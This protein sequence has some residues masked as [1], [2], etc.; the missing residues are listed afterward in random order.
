MYNTYNSYLI[1]TVQSSTTSP[2]GNILMT[3]LKLNYKRTLFVGFAFFLILTF[4]QTYDSIIP[5][6]LTDKFGLSQLWSGVIMAA[7]N[8]MAVVLLPL[9]GAIS[10]RHQSRL[11]RRTPFILVGTLAAA[12]ALVG[13]SF[14]DNMQL[15]AIDDISA[16]VQDADG[17]YAEERQDAIIKLYDSDVVIKDGKT[18]ADL[19]GTEADFILALETDED[20]AEHLTLA[21]QAYAWKR[22]CEDPV[23]LIIFIV[24]LLVVLL[25]MAIFRSPAV[26]LMPDITPK[27]LRSKANAII[28]LMGTAGGILVLVLGIVFGTGKT[29]NILMSYTTFFAVVACVML[30]ALAI[31]MITVRE[32]KWAEENDEINRILDGESNEEKETEEKH[33]LGLSKGEKRSLLFILASVVL[34]YIG[35]NAVTSKYS[36]YA[37]DVLGLDF[38]LTLIV[39]QAAAIV[40]YIPVGIISQKVGRR[41]TILAGVAMLFTAFFAASFMRAGSSAIV[42]NILFALAGIGWATINVNSYPM[43]VEMA[44]SDNVGKYTG[45]YYTASMAAQIFAP[46]ISGFFLTYVGMTTLFPF[47]AIF[48]GGA[49]ITMFIVKHGDAK[50]ETKGDI[51]EHLDAA[52]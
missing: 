51:L 37:G 33:G 47:G 32:V 14:V 50:P 18:L 34:W 13:L 45:I 29:G 49:F 3:K 2:K 20:A 36:V 10:D 26:A 39:A 35:Y 30:I 17:E 15:T 41:K 38:N 7:D 48:V 23:N 19:Y 5:K 42:L 27:P 25:S 40:S 21:R 43:V 4:W 22:T 16:V 28:N 8:V 11:G 46:I 1:I 24:L 52:D 31:F 12:V 44:K 6:I 9:F